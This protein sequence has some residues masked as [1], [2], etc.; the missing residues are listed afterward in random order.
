MRLICG[1]VAIAAILVV[2]LPARAASP[3]YVRDPFSI[4]LARHP[5]TIRFR[6]VDLT[7]LRWSNWGKTRA[8]AKGRANVLV[9]DPTCADG[10]RIPGSAAVTVRRRGRQGTRLVYRCIEGRLTGVPAEVR[11]ISWD[12]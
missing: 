3:V 5:R 4:R 7:R 6:D 9:C 8:T 2:T 12:C 11:R 1:V 10:R